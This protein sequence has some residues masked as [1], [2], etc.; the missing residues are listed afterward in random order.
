MRETAEAIRKN[1]LPHEHDKQKENSLWKVSLDAEYGPR[2]FRASLE[3]ILDST[4]NRE[5]WTAFT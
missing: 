1:K 4:G 5:P 3:F 2:V